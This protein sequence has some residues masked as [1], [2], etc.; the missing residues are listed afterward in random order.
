MPL[1][2]AGETGKSP[3]EASRGDY[4]IQSLTQQDTGWRIT[5]LYSLERYHYTLFSQLAFEVLIGLAVMAVLA[6]VA[7]C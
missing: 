2:S 4:Y 7:F 6:V 5:E 3:A 1:Q